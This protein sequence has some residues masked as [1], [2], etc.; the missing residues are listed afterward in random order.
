M[1]FGHAARRFGAA[2]DLDP[3]TVPAYLNIGDV[4]V[5]DF[6][7]QLENGGGRG[8]AQQQLF[9]KRG[10]DLFNHLSLR[11]QRSDD[12]RGN[13]RGGDGNPETVPHGNKHKPPN[14]ESDK[15]DKEV[16]FFHTIRC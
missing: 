11:R 12:R 2:I 6:A 13:D 1:E 4:H 14:E 9:N 15:G 10:I 16:I 5:L 8:M 7:L 3:K